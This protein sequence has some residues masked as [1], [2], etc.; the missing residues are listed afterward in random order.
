MF[1]C[2]FGV[3]MA[4]AA[5]L[6]ASTTI[7]GQGQ[8]R[9]IGGVGIT[10]YEDIGYGGENATFRSDQPDLS[11]SRLAGRISSLRVAN[12][13]MWEGCEGTDYRPP[14]QVFS[15]SETDLR[16]VNWSDRISSLRRIQDNG[17]RGGG[18]FPP[19]RPGYTARAELVLYSDERFRGDTRVINGPTSSLG[20]WNDRAES[21]RINSGTWEVCEDI[22][23]GKCRT[24]NHEYQ[25]LGALG[26]A[27]RISSVRPVLTERGPG[28]YSG[29]RPQLERLV[30]YDREQ[31]RGGART[32]NAASNDLGDAGNRAQSVQVIGTW[33]L[34]EG[35]NFSGRC[36]TLSQNVPDLASHGLSNRIASARPLGAR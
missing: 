17:N 25:T 33:Q 27:K 24:I 13:E 4:L 15:G 18:I 31:Y 12:G 5:T 16:R 2:S 1:E 30:L 23:F 9:Q 14:C 28:G 26:L 3:A 20:S 36:I 35:P 10:V 6:C 7:A 29:A 8:S 21:V 11:S 32:L 22:D 34:C 19:G